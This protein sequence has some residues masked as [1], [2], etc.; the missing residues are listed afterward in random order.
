MVSSFEM[1]LVKY[2]I[3]PP[4]MVK[5]A[6]SKQIAS[7]TTQW[8]HFR[9]HPALFSMTNT[10]SVAAPLS[11]YYSRE[12]SPDH[13]SASLVITEDLVGHVVGCSSYG[14]KQVT[15]ISSAQVSAF[16]Q[17]VNGHLEC[18]VSIRGTDKQLGNTLVVL[19]KWIARKRMS[20]SRKKKQGTATSGPVTAA[21]SPLP[22][23]ALLQPSAPSSLSTLAHQTTTSACGRARPTWAS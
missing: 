2:S 1:L 17:E 15:D 22:C 13:F 23:V 3:P 5:T 7:T 16:T 19:G 8:D 11:A 21:P 10:K 4:T 18:I 6:Q 9:W 14:L 12:F 20:V